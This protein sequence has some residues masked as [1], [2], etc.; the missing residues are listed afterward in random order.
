MNITIVGPGAMG[1]L[2]ASLLAN[3]GHRVC[4]LDKS[5]DRASR[6]AS[7]GLRLTGASGPLSV[8]PLAT[9]DAASIPAPDLVIIAVKAYDTQA[10]AASIAPVLAEH[11]AV[12]TLQNGMGNAEAIAAAVGAERVIA[13]TTG[14]G[15]HLLDVGEVRHAGSGRTVIGRLARAEDAGLRQVA[16][17]LTAA[18]LETTT[19]ANVEPVLWRKLVVNAAIN[20]LTALMRLP[21]G[22]L[23]STPER[24]RLLDRVVDEAVAVV[25]GAGIVLPDADMRGRVHTVCRNT[26]TNRSSM[27]QDVLRGHR[28][29]IDAINGALLEQAAAAGVAAPVNELLVTLVRALSS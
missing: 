13:G 21:N 12:V 18:G 29:E 22:D 15:A 23:L 10:A 3:A 26:A 24:R 25:E 2:F 16:A 6:I 28:T 4:L 9:A 27:L 11:T 8:R 7:R 1:C 20:P 17:L 5:S 14:H 19:A